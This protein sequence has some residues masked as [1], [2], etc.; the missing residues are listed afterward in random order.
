[1]R[2]IYARLR[3]FLTFQ[4]NWNGYGAVAFS[5]IYIHNCIDLVNRLHADWMEVYPLSDGRVQLESSYAGN[6]IE[7]EVNPNMTLSVYME[8]LDGTSTEITMTEQQFYKLLADTFP[9]RYEDYFWEDA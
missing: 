2:D 9:S 7:A 6:Y 4:D 1:M 3:K 5:E 8:T